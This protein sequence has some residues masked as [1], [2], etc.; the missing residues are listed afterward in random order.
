MILGSMQ[1]TFQ[2]FGDR[3]Y[4]K[5]KELGFE[6]VDYYVGGELNGMTE[7]EYDA[8][9]FAEKEKMERAGVYTHQTHGPWRFP[10]H[11]ETEEARAERMDAMKRSLRAT[12]LLGCRYW[13]IHPLMPFGH[14]ND[15]NFEDFWKINLDFFKKLLP[16]AKQYGII[17]CFENMPMRSLSISPVPK[18]LEFINAINDESFQFCLDT[19]HCWIRGMKPGDAVRMAGKTLK[20]LHV[21]DNVQ[22]PDPH[23]VPG[24]GTI[25]WDDFM[26]ALHEIGYDGVLSL[27]CE[28]DEFFPA[29]DLDT[30]FEKL[31]EIAFALL[32][33][34]S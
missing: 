24:E 23:S 3:C 28:L 34:K 32:N 16:T 17:I 25:D 33:K 19:G 26:A 2:C 12:A 9:I 6:A 1:S 7:E 15:G 11:D 21:H 13:V 18:T 10:P 8:A 5:M 20:V 22:L 31:K 27:E 30:R 29:L 4:E 14:R